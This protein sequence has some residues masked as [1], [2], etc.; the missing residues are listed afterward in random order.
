MAEHEQLDL[1]T[2]DYARAGWTV[3]SRTANAVALEKDTEKARLFVDADGVVRVDGPALPAL[4][5]D[6]RMRAWLALL[7]VLMAVFAVAW[8][9]GFFK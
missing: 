3:T 7:L 1:L 2:R 4:L 9:L 8:A 5:L 6:G